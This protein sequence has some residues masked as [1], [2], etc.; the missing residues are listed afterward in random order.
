MV[1]SGVQDGNKDAD[2]A[3][4]FGTVSQ[5]IAMR[6]GEERAGEIADRGDDDREMIAAVPEAVVRSLVAKDLGICESQES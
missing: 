5:R 2:N 1:L 6:V 4:S 3:I